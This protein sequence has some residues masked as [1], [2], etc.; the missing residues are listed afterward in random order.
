M[1]K[2][3]RTSQ[4]DDGAAHES[5]VRKVFLYLRGDLLDWIEAERERTRKSSENEIEVTAQSVIQAKL[6]KQMRAETEI[7]S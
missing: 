7:G 6:R 3:K 2:K 5:A 1:N 4:Q